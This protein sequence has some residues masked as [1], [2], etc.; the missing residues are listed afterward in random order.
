MINLTLVGK[1][2]HSL[3]AQVHQLIGFKDYLAS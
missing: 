2:K 1:R 3:L